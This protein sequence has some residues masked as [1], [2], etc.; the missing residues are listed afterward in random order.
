MRFLTLL[1][2]ATLFGCAS[3][4]TRPP[5]LPSPHS[6]ID[7]R[8]IL[9][10]WWSPEQYQSAAFWIKDSTIYYPEHF[11][12]YRYT[13]HGESLIIYREEGEVIA[14]TILK[15]TPDTLILSASGQVA[16]YTR[17][18]TQQK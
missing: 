10:I 13:L 8:A 3:R 12:E 4:E 17:S 5:Q 1:L 18:E 6:S 2:L 15:V 14:S 11:A 16:L 9:G 7:R